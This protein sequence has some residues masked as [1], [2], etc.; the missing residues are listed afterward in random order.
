MDHYIPK[1]SVC[2][3][4]VVS[5]LTKT[6]GTFIRPQFCRPGLQRLSYT[7]LSNIEDDSGSKVRLII[8]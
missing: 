8:S 5:G 1:Y 6:A 7:I 2:P 4:N 3:Y